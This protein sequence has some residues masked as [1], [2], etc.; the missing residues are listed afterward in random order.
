MSFMKKIKKVSG[1]FNDKNEREFI[2]HNRRIWGGKGR[3]SGR[4]V[5]VEFNNLQHCI[6]SWSYYANFFAKKYNAEIYSYAEK[7]NV[8]DTG[9][10]RIYRSFNTKAFITEIL[11]N[12]ALKEIEK[13]YNNAKK[14]I[15]TKKDLV[16]F[17]VNGINIG[18]DIYEQYLIEGHPT[19]DLS[20]DRVYVLLKKAVK[21]LMF[22]QR[23]FKD[24]DVCVVIISHNCYL[25]NV[26][27]RIANTV[28]I[29]VYQITTAFGLKLD[30]GVT[31]GSNFP[32]YRELFMQLDDK[33]KRWIKDWAKKQLE[34]RFSGE[35]G[36]DMSYS[37]KS[38]FGE[39]KDNPVLKKSDRLK[40]LICSHCFFDNPYCY[41]KDMLFTDFYE[42]LCF[43]GEIAEKTEY[44]WYLKIH[45]DY[46]PGTK[47]TIA[48]ILKRYP[49]IIMVPEDTSHLQLVKEGIDYVF[50]VYGTVGCEYPLMGVPV[51]NAGNNPHIMY[52]F[53]YNPKTIEE[54]KDIIFNLC[55]LHKKINKDEIYEF[56]GIHHQFGTY[57]SVN[58]GM[59]D[60]ILWSNEKMFLTLKDNVYS[61]QA[62]SYFLNEISEDRHKEILNNV[63]R[64]YDKIHRYK[65]G[66]LAEEW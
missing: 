66:V 24:N 22:W 3:V 33:K 28:N 26:I 64:Y 57:D 39:I 44:D 19:V 59:D 37:K 34:R 61:S 35:I 6:L 58:R 32:H 14:M 46:R 31:L 42:W 13:I 51:I 12:E 18:Q 55:N 21:K 53:C 23:Y 17:E 20:D 15:K 52:D 4:K 2:S 62:Y 54:Y 45:P 11:E 50:T 7:F 63:Q 43:L 16:D 40:I 65:D 36:V 29:P 48:K 30:A 47:E 8:F 27:R 60:M 25:M 10:K 56:Y 38:S 1:I 49:R 9:L 5:L 41:G